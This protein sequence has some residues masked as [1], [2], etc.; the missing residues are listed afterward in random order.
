MWP[1][2]DK[3]KDKDKMTLMKKAL[4]PGDKIY[5]NKGGLKFVVKK[6]PT[7]TPTRPKSKC[8]HKKRPGKKR[9]TCF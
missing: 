2:M 5:N 1:M 3:N 9:P 4:S 6:T 7:P 8:T